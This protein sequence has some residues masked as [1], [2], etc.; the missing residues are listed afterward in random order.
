MN[1]R[2]NRVKI[3][4]K[5][6]LL[7]SFTYKKV[8]ATAL[9]STNHNFKKLIAS[10]PIADIIKL[11]FKVLSALKLNNTQIN[12]EANLQ[13]SFNS[14]LS[15]GKIAIFRNCKNLQSIKCQKIIN[16]LLGSFIAN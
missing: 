16:E 4:C 10:A 2:T 3:C 6:K 5:F 13:K 9:G 7:L 14:D 15:I 1:I 11:S 8:K 12:K